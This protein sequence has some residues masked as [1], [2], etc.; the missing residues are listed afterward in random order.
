MKLDGT[1]LDKKFY[2]SRWDKK[3]P[4]YAIGIFLFWE[5][6]VEFYRS[7]PQV[8]C[9]TVSPVGQAFTKHTLGHITMKDIEK[10]ETQGKLTT[11]PTSCPT[12]VNSTSILALLAKPEVISALPKLASTAY[13]LLLISLFLMGKVSGADLTTAVTLL[14]GYV[15]ECL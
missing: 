2:Q 13:V 3:R 9:S 4:L 14:A 15:K 10:T 5:R 7:T 11:I 12:C 8:A 6:R 1:D